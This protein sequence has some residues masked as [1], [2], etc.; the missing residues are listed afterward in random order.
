MPDFIHITNPE[1]YVILHHVKMYGGGA[2]KIS[3]CSYPQN[4]GF[5]QIKCNRLKKHATWRWQ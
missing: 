5:P 2:N 4:F 1:G 3:K